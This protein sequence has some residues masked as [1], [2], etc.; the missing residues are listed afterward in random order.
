MKLKEFVNTLKNQTG[1]LK[2][3]N[4]KC[5][6]CQ[7][8]LEYEGSSIVEGN[9]LFYCFCDTCNYSRNVSAKKILE[10]QE[11]T[12][13]EEL[14]QKYAEFVKQKIDESKTMI[15]DEWYNYSNEID[16]NIWSDDEGIIYAAAY[17]VIDGKTQTDHWVD[18]KILD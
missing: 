6:E 1:T 2:E 16:I 3:I 15:E 18:I 14:K 8:E 4:T 5:W 11:T 17:D 7:D 12:G 9:M 10:E 13:N